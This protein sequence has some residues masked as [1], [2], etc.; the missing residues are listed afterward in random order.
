MQGEPEA[1][2]VRRRNIRHSPPLCAATYPSESDGEIE[3]NAAIA[4]LSIQNSIT[5]FRTIPIQV[6]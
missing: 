4:I 6:L 5:W 1:T 3:N 2:N